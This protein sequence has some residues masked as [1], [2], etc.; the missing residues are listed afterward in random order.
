LLACPAVGAANE[1]A[2]D[3]P[4][5]ATAINKRKTKEREFRFMILIIGSSPT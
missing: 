1:S 4:I 3:K 5:A 2:P